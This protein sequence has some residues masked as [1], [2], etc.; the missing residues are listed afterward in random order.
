MNLFRSALIALSVVAMGARA[1]S[2]GLDPNVVFDQPSPFARNGELLRRLVSP[3]Q[4][5]RIEDRLGDRTRGLDASPLDRAQQHFALYV[6]SAPPPAA[7]YRLLVFVPPWSDAR[8]PPQWLGVLDRTRTIF[9]TG[10][11]SGNDADVLR[12]REPLALLAAWNVMRRYHVDPGRVYIGGFSGGARVALR[13]ALGYPEVFRGALLDAGSDPIGTAQVPL[14]PASTLHRFQQ[15]SRI[16]FVTGDADHIR[17]A[18]RMRAGTALQTWCAFN[19]DDIRLPHTAHA[20][21]DASGLARAFDSLSKPVIPDIQRIQACRARNHA[22]L[23]GDFRRV[24]ALVH[25]G[26]LDEAAHALDAADA[27]YGGLAA[28]RS[29][30]LLQAIEARAAPPR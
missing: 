11:Q 10:A 26:R 15:A 29:L 22:A 8:V 3:L 24:Q 16:V 18:Q 14:P 28:P 1:S 23:A 6:P 9:V 12:R 5:S 4:A 27:R 20:L 19:I 7:G 21:A 25:A 2:S 17:Q 30:E 13:L